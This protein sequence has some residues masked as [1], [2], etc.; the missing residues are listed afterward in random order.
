MWKKVNKGV[1]RGGV[2]KEPRNVFAVQ[3]GRTQAGAY[4]IIPHWAHR[5]ATRCTIYSDGAKLAF[6]LGAR[7]DYAVTESGPGSRTRKVSIPTTFAKALPYGTTD[8]S[9]DMDGDMIV[10]DLTP[11]A[12]RAAAE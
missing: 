5:D 3:R 10:I 2:A 8:I 9:Y 7:G 4:L 11:F 12:I 1:G 6:A